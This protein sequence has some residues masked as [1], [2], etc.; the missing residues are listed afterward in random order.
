MM[1]IFERHFRISLFY[2]N[3]KDYSLFLPIQCNVKF[4]SRYT[5]VVNNRLIDT[6][7]HS[8]NRLSL[9]FTFYLLILA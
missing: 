8:N 2:L 6:L 9:S 3:Y 4:I 5:Q 1:E 7:S